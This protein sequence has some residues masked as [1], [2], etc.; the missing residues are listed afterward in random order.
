MTIK[1][2]E[3]LNPDFIQAHCNGVHVSVKVFTLL[4][5]S[6]I[7]SL[8]AVTFDIQFANSLYPNQDRHN[9]RVSKS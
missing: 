4:T 2:I 7:L 3:N 6:V 1:R 5:S 9:V 8:L